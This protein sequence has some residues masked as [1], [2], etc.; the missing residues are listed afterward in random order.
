MDPVWFSYDS[1]AVKCHLNDF[2]LGYSKEFKE[3]EGGPKKVKD[4]SEVVLVQS[5]CDS[6]GK[7]AIQMI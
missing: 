7:K 6:S 2:R 4:G 1:S 5:P 3:K